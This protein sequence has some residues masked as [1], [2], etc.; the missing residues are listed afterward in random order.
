MELLYSIYN[1]G[2]EKHQSIEVGISIPNMKPTLADF[3]HMSE[4]RT[5]YT[6]YTDSLDNIDVILKEFK[7]ELGKVYNRHYTT[8]T[9]KKTE[10]KL[11]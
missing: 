5:I 4:E 9:Y 11:T 7:L 10:E 1:D 3:S 8:I 6:F 2:K